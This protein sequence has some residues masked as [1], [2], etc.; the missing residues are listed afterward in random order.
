MSNKH[1]KHK[2]R[3]NFSDNDQYLKGYT[4]GLADASDSILS[5]AYFAGVGAGKMA[6]GDTHIGF[7]SERE[8]ELYNKGFEDRDK[9]FK[10][11]RTTKPSF[12][13]MLFG[14]GGTHVGSSVNKKDRKKARFNAR[15]EYFRSR[16][17][18]RKA[19]KASRKAS[20][21]AR[22][23]RIKGRINYWKKKWK[24]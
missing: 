21:N 7:N 10:S 5:D 20:R 22:K 9:H 18:E 12:L 3:N 4:A 6:A 23:S 1:N 13:E 19:R 2:S 16:K 24:R 17:K 14:I 8:R 15:A 11:F